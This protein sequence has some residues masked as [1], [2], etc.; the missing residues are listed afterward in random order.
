MEIILSV[1]LWV[2]IIPVSACRF[3]RNEF[4]GETPAP[5]PA[6]LAAGVWVLGFRYHEHA[7]IMA[8]GEH[9]LIWSPARVRLRNSRQSPPSLLS[10]TN[11]GKSL[12]NVICDP[13][14]LTQHVCFPDT[15]YCPTQVFE[16]TLV[17]AV[18]RDIALELSDP[19]RGVVASSKLCEATVK[20]AAMPEIAIA[21]DYDSL[22]GKHYVRATRQLTNVKAISKT[23]SPKLVA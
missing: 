21:E 17:L 10:G 12:G 15:H 5:D 7:K 11:A 9:G 8:I 4:D 1:K 16:R 18:S 6:I 13:C 23:P 3:N 19:V 2:G 14:R 20:I 22:L